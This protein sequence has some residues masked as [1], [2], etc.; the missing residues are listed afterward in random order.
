ML[1]IILKHYSLI[2]TLKFSK[3]S[4]YVDSDFRIKK[5]IKICFFP[6]TSGML[7]KV[8]FKNLK[9]K[10]PEYMKSESYIKKSLTTIDI[11]A[12][13]KFLLGC[14]LLLF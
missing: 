2:E 4:N 6:Q 8:S 9:F 12:F 3:E 10:T 14:Y 5:V 1:Q 13:S 11:L 7:S